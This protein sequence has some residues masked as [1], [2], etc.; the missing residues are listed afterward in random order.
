MYIQVHTGNALHTCSSLP[1]SIHA[2]TC[3]LSC[4]QV[5]KCISE[6]EKCRNRGLKKEQLEELDTATKLKEWLEAGKDVRWVQCRPALQLQD[7]RSE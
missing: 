6:I 5:T 2:P 4:G 3:T 1:F 7:L